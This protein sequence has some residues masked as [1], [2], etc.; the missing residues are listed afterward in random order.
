M[1]AAAAPTRWIDCT[2]WELDFFGLPKRIPWPE[3]VAPEVANNSP[4]EIEHMLR[5]IEDLGEQA[6]EPWTSFHR[7]AEP[8][9]DLAEALE[10]GEIRRAGELLD[11][12]EAAFPGTS[13]SLFHRAFV[14]RHE[15]REEE[16]IE[17]YRQ[18][19]EKTPGIGAVWNNY[20]TVLMLS[21]KRDEAVGAFKQALQCT[22]ND[23]LALEGLAQCGQLIKVRQPTPEHPN[24][25]VYLDHAT[26]RKMILQQI[27][28][29]GANPDALL[30]MGQQLLREGV[31]P[32]MGVAALERAHETRADHS[33][34]MLAL[35]AGY[36]MTN[37]HD[38]ARAILTRHS[39]VLPND[40]NGFFHLAQACQAAG[41]AEAEQAALERT[42]ALEPNHPSAL[43]IR[44][45][46]GP[47]EHD[48]ALEE[49]LSRFGAE[50][51]SWRAFV[52]AAGIARARGDT[53]SALRAIERA[54]ALAPADEEVLAHYATIL[55]DAKDL[56]K[57]AEVIKPAVEGA[58][59]SKR[60]DWVYAQVLNQVGLLKD[61]SE[62]LRRA[63]ATSTS[64]DFKQM[65]STTI[66]AWTGLLTGCGVRLEVH[67][68]G[69]LPRALVISLA[70][71]DGGV[72]IASGSQVPAQG[73]FPWRAQGPEAVVS[74]QQGESGGAMEIRALGAFR[75]RG[76]QTPAG[77]PA[78]IECHVVAL[79]DGALHFRAQQD[80]RR[81]QVGWMRTA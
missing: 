21:G 20:G 26:Y 38:K 44:Y 70:D 31:A 29:Q 81:L 11:Q 16:A 54:F 25:V 36:R 35:G 67:P 8:L 78:T 19:T 53:P 4:F 48:P 22:A 64:D 51:S 1:T 32:E 76:V 60:L 3:N 66:E 24:A 69:F 39:E 28:G 73:R 50:R 58:K 14:A 37:Q 75:V 18:S 33:P 72:V 13:F 6:G 40:A 55:G 62:V 10:D 74:L 80:G 15:G 34:T 7:A 23:P 57:L 41:D 5:A 61:A 17:L 46:V 43:A 30:T 71:G 59:Y 63:I 49:E 42:I 52:L 45:K 9:D 27:M 79:P 12:F 56:R 77:A 47:T 68:A 2:N 65:A